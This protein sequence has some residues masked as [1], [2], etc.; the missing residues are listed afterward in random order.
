HMGSLLA[1]LVY[2]WRDVLAMLKGCIDALRGRITRDAR[3]VFYILI[4]TVPIVLVGAA[5]KFTGL[6]EHLRSATL[7]AWNAII[8]GILLYLAD[9][10]G[11]MRR[12]MEDMSW[13][14]AIIIGIAQALA[15]NPGTS[16]S[17]ITITA[18][19]SLG[20]LRPDAARY[21]F[22]LSIPATAAAGFL[23][24]GD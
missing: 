4:G 21:S 15:L 19:R 6:T 8:F 2:F 11:L 12:T 18:A 20:F 10:F 24:I 1:V 7:V 9:R 17:G 5:I 23:V 14:P 22:L 3:L 13:K 16:R